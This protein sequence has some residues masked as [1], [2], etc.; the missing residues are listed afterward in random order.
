MATRTEL[1]EALR[2]A[3]GRSGCLDDVRARVR[4]EV[5]RAF[6]PA[7][8]GDS[9][10]GGGRVAR[11]VG[12]R[13]AEGLLAEDLVRELLEWNGYR[14]TLSVFEAEVP[15]GPLQSR[16]ALERR[17]NVVTAGAE[18]EVPLLYSLI[19][20]AQDGTFSEPPSRR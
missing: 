1:Q 4:G 5:L 2:G 18:R 3:L 14:Q 15:P 17:V 16:D 19:R 8:P 11:G 9:E 6:D 13:P 7:A 20:A 12:G 10:G